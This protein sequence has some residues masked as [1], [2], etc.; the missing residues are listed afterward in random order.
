[1]PHHK[2]C[3]KRLRKSGEERVRNNALKTILRKTIKDARAKISD[4]Q[5]ID[6]NEAY[7]SIDKVSGKG[8]IPKKR[9]SRIKSRLAR[10]AARVAAKNN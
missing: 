6:L 7:S 4:K 10:A 9:A 8:I 2:S 3:K 1:M 5:T